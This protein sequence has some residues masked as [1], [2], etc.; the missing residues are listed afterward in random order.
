MPPPRSCHAHTGCRRLRQDAAALAC[1]SRLVCRRAVAAVVAALGICGRRAT[2]SPGCRSKEETG[3]SLQLCS[4]SSAAY[5]VT[6]GRETRRTLAPLCERRT[7]GAVPVGWPAAHRNSATAFS[8]SRYRHTTVDTRQATAWH[9]PLRLTASPIQDYQ[10]VSYR[11]PHATVARRLPY[12]RPPG[13]SRRQR[14]S[15]G[16]TPP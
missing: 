13:T 8:S 14:T 12:A 15:Y 4:R 1:V 7:R 9:T 2:Q 11:K 10:D 3:L 6:Y 16:F 5:G